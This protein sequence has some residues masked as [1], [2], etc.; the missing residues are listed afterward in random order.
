MTASPGFL[1]DHH[2]QPMHKRPVKPFKKNG[3][4]SNMYKAYEIHKTPKVNMTK[5]S[6]VSSPNLLSQRHSHTWHLF[7]TQ[8]CKTSEKGEQKHAFL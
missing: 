2:T 7:V 5:L 3:Q 8:K 1:E 4:A 6:K